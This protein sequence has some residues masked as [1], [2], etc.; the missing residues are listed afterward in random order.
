MIFSSDQ[1]HISYYF[2][3]FLFFPI[4]AFIILNCSNN[5]I[6]TCETG[7]LLLLEKKLISSYAVLRIEIFNR[8]PNTRK[9]TQ[10]GVVE[11][12][13]KNLLNGS[14]CNEKRLE[15]ELEDA[16]FEHVT[17]ETTDATEENVKMSSNSVN[18][19]V[20]NGI[21]WS[22]YI[23]DFSNSLLE[24]DMEIHS[25]YSEDSEEEV[26][27]ET[28]F[29]GDVSDDYFY[30][31][32][33]TLA[34]R[35]RDATKEDI[36]F[37]AKFNTHKPDAIH[38]ELKTTLLGISAS[39]G[40]TLAKLVTEQKT[41]FKALLGSLLF[42]NLLSL[43]FPRKKVNDEAMLYRSVKPNPDP[44]RVEETKFMT[45]DEMSECCN[46]PSTNWIQAGSGSLGIV[47]LEILTCQGLVK[48][49]IGRVFGN[50]NNSFVCAVY[51]DCL[52]ETDVIPDCLNPMWMPWTQRAFVF[53]RMHALGSIYLAVF[54][55]DSGPFKDRGCGRTTVDLREFEPN[56][57]Y[58]LTYDLFSS[59]VLSNRK[60]RHSNNSSFVNVEKNISFSHKLL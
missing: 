30:G 40:L 13:V 22:K 31:N 36:Q 11:I 42:R 16:S 7:S 50:Q 46:S 24:I 8:P 58:N 21:A 59:P 5:P 20:A 23:Y 45:K 34:L 53:N 33:G 28:I 1:N 35:F 3:L 17:S 18:S 54:D 55:H 41:S 27:D 25:S 2:Y 9:S 15:F 10:I 44:A 37:L 6:W 29:V 51:D 14:L 19:L 38:M 43:R 60:V 56:T 57:V 26:D 12:P 39:D 32:I 52:V 4:F 49:D 47:M 48:K